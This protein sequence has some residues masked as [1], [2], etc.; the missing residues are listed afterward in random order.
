MWTSSWISKKVFTGVKGAAGGWWAC[1]LLLSDDNL[2]SDHIRT[3]NRQTGL[4]TLTA[5][6]HVDAV[7]VFVTVEAEG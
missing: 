5:H 2:G 6:V 7:T 4:K 1:D 3:T